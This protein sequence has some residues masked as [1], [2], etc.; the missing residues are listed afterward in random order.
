MMHTFQIITFR[1]PVKDLNGKMGLL[2]YLSKLDL[3]VC[4]HVVDKD[5]A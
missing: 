4:K 5:S 3:F 2:Q 1:K